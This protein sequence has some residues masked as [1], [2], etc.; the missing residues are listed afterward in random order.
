MNVA[1]ISGRNPTNP[2][3]CGDFAGNTITLYS[4]AQKPNGSTINCLTGPQL[5]DNV[6]HEMGH[7]LGLNHPNGSG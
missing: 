7:L 2:S 4:E 5:D 1:V 3:S 6:T